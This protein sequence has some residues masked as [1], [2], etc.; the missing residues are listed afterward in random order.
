M[1]RTRRAQVVLTEDEYALIERYATERKQSVSGVI[2]ETMRKYVVNDLERQRKL[3]AV[4]WLAAGDAPVSDWPEMEREIMR[5]WE[6]KP[7]A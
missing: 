1:K 2:R 7:H 3:E 5:R 6:D 4:A